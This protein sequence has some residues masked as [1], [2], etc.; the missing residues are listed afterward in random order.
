PYLIEAGHLFEFGARVEDIDECMLD[1]GMPMG[2]LRLIDEVGADVCHHV[3]TDLAGKVRERMQAH[4]DL[5]RMVQDGLLGKKNGQGFYVHQKKAKEPDVNPDI[6]QY[7]SDTSC[8]GL[9]RSALCNRM[10]LLMINEAA[11]CL[12]EK[13]VSEPADIDFGM[14]MGT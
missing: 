9:G 12:E 3:A 14:I 2:P 5:T 13:V 1:F 8:A 4:G 6:D 10:V 7:H 11:R